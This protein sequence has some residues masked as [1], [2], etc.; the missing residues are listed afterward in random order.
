ME[1]LKNSCS[2]SIGNASIDRQSSGGTVPKIW[3]TML[4]TKIANPQSNYKKMTIC[5]VNPELGIT[6]YFLAN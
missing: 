6:H 4:R 3:P 1:M 2:N 5:T